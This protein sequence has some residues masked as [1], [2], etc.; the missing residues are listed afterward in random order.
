MNVCNHLGNLVRYDSLPQFN[1]KVDRLKDGLAI[2]KSLF[3]WC[4]RKNGNY[5]V[6]DSGV[7][8]QP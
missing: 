3:H 2:D 1:V 5:R 4:A 8:A 7:F 6:C